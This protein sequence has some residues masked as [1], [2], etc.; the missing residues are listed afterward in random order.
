M[1]KFRII[2]LGDELQTS[3]GSFDHL[4]KNLS[5]N[6]FSRTKVSI[7]EN[8]NARNEIDLTKRSSYTYDE[9]VNVY[10][11]SILELTDND[12]L[13]FKII[14]YNKG[15]FFTSHRDHKGMY[16]CLIMGGTEFKGGVLSLK[17][18]LF[19][20]KINPDNLKNRFYMIIFSIDIYHEVSPILEGQRFILKT[21]INKRM[22]LDNYK[23]SSSNTSNKNY[24]TG[25]EV[26][27]CI[28]SSDEEYDE[29]A[30]FFLGGQSDGDY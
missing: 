15:D 19:D 27:D 24:K 28:S 16:T 11:D 29:P 9:E 26:E 6:K 17:N 25:C 12:L 8:G 5:N 30:G 7:I 20:I 22:N 4:I 23:K 18:E 10:H 13:K 3:K 2:D 21:T 1:D 14:K